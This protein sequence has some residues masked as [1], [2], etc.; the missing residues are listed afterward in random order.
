MECSCQIEFCLALSHLQHNL[1]YVHF[2]C[3][4]CISPATKLADVTLTPDAKCYHVLNCVVEG[5]W[6]VG[7]FLSV[8]KRSIRSF[9]Y[10]KY[11]IIYQ[12]L[13]DE[14]LVS[15]GYTNKP[16]EGLD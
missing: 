14:V 15:K 4:Y 13:Q 16:R 1:P 6:L 7:G 8:K 9:Y 5:T 10:I 11:F 2:N 12:Q 3:S